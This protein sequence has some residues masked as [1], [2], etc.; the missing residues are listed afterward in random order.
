METIREV[1]GFDPLIESLKKFPRVTEEHL[2]H[3]DFFIDKLG[4]FRYEFLNDFEIAKPLPK[5]LS[6]LDYKSE[7]V[8]KSVSN[9]SNA[10]RRSNEFSESRN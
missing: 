10:I 8:T 5:L 1:H 3:F 4:C 6:F 7:C 2:K 9:H